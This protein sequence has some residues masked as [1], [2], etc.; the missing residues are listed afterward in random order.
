MN[1]KYEIIVIDKAGTRIGQIINWVG[2]SFEK[3]L[4][5]F[6]SCIIKVPLLDE[7]LPELIA[8]RR[9]EVQIYRDGALL[10]AGEQVWVRSALTSEAEGTDILEL[11]CYDYLEMFNARYTDLEDIYSTVDAGTI[12]WTLIDESQTL[13]NGDLGITQG[14]IEATQNRDRTYYNQNIME[15]IVNL[16]KVIGGFDFEITPE[17]V[18]NVYALK[19]LDRSSFAIFEYGVNFKTVSISND[20]G[21]PSNFSIAVGEGTGLSKLKETSENVPS[22]E[23]IKLRQQLT[24]ENSVS[25]LQTLQDKADDITSRFST[26]VLSLTFMQSQKT[27]PN[28]GSIDLGDY[29]KVR[30]DRGVFDI[31]NLF[32]V[33][34]IKVAVD[35]TGNEIIE[36]LV[37]IQ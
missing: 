23:S 17:K 26:P 21:T 37:N 8:P 4:N 33:Y 29:V 16:S 5:N 36:Y 7:A 15:A 18:F 14:N 11:I 6:G 22:Q 12:A 24:V 31:D 2:F 3:K 1:N 28:L 19:G 32:R 20:F 30:V 34:G 13:T 25:V 35:Q 27:N 9:Y 10:W